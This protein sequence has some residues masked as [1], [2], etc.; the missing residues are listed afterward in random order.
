LTIEYWWKSL[1][2]ASTFFD[3]FFNLI[4]RRRTFNIQLS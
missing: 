1:R 4:R 2:S 3:S